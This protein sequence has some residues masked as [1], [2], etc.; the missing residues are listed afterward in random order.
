MKVC[1]RNL[2]QQLDGSWL[3]AVV[4]E[5]NEIVFI[6]SPYPARGNES[7]YNGKIRFHNGDTLK[8]D[9]KMYEALYTAMKVRNCAEKPKK[10]EKEEVRQSPIPRF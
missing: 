10:N 8:L 6:E 2:K 3:P 4:V 7:T 1:I 5:T 9:M